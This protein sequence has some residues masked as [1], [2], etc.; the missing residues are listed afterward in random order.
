M[1]NLNLCIIETHTFGNN[2]NKT[3]FHCKSLLNQELNK[4]LIICTYS[5]ALLK[6]GLH[7]YVV[8]KD[9]IKKST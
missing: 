2:G 5:F 8:Y 6:Y 1:N 4:H 9:K 3:S 7:V